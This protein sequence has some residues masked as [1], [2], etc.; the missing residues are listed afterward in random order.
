MLIDEDAFEYSLSPKSSLE[1]SI[2]GMG[3]ISPRHDR[4][5]GPESLSR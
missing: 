2:G 5:A 3:G 4:P 1:A